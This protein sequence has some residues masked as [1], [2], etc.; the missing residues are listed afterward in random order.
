M[1]TEMSAQR[2]RRVD[3]EFDN[4][5][6]KLTPEQP[7]GPAKRQIQRVEIGQQ[8]LFVHNDDHNDNHNDDRDDHYDHKAASSNATV[9]ERAP[10]KRVKT[11]DPWWQ[12]DDNEVERRQLL[13]EVDKRD[14]IVVQRDRMV[15]QLQEEV[16]QLRVQK[17]TNIITTTNDMA[18]GP[19][20][21]H[22]NIGTPPLDP[23]PLRPTD[24]LADA[25]AGIRNNT[26]QN[27][28]QIKPPT[29]QAGILHNE[30]RSPST[31]GTPY[32][33]REYGAVC[34]L[35]GGTYPGGD[36]DDG[37]NDGDNNHE[38]DRDK[39]HNYHR[40]FTL[41]SPNKIVVPKFSGTQLGSRPYMPCN[42]A[43]KTLIKAQ[44]AKGFQ[45]F[46]ILQDIEKYGDKPCDSSRLAALAEIG[47]KAYEYNAAIQI[48][49]QTCTIDVVENMCRYGVHNGFDAW[50]K[51]YHHHVPLAEDLQ[52]ILIQELCELKPVSE[53][54]VDK[55]FVEIQRISEWYT[56]V[57]THCMN[58]V[59]LW[60]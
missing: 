45:L 13:E 3:N 31:D 25:F 47:T 59:A 28:I 42:K 34:Q 16:R 30:Q 18:T 4:V 23:N 2:P 60:A 37:S 44:G 27:N 10:K 35:G 32:G 49:L 11:S 21:M 6:K 43:I 38:T 36:P 40:E 19:P 29:I 9:L 39:G 48:V 57:G 33:A 58:V 46:P 20:P 56:R 5:V 26:V 51:L 52:E 15:E 54:D 12:G 1:P 22:R 50:R 8:L 17:I 24:N 55:L 14:K 41:V 7:L 53:A